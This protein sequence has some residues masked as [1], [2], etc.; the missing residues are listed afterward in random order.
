MDIPVLPISIP[1]GED[2][3]NAEQ[4]VKNIVSGHD[5]LLVLGYAN[6][7]GDKVLDLVFAIIAEMQEPTRGKIMALFDTAIENSATNDIKV[8]EA[9]GEL[10]QKKINARA[11]ANPEVSAVP[12]DFSTFKKAEETFSS[13]W[14]LP[15]YQMQEALTA[16]IPTYRKMMNASGN[17][18]FVEVL[19]FDSKFY[20]FKSQC[21]GTLGAS[22]QTKAMIKK[23]DDIIEEFSRD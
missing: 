18:N 16:I 1:P 5:L 4:F 15:D 11:L 10:I 6:N 3:V 12:L 8:L 23:I 9:Y 13:I 7:C 20:E 21:L 2:R 14:E 17:I 22:E 19:A